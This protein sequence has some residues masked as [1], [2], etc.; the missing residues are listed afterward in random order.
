MGAPRTEGG[1][2]GGTLGDYRG[3]GIEINNKL[4]NNK[5]KV[6]GKRLI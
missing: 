2:H 3:S 1:R 5:Q 6:K 4:K